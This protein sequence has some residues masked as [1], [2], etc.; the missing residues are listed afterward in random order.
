M[1]YLLDE[2][3]PPFFA[4]LLNQTFYPEHENPVVLSARYLDFLGI[5][6]GDWIPVLE[7]Q[8][9]D[10]NEGWTVVTRDRMD[11]HRTEMFASTLKFAILADANWSSARRHQLWENL[12]RH[13]PTLE[14]HSV[15]PLSKV[16]RMSYRGHISE[17]K[18]SP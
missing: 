14:R 6:D 13:W 7:Q 9:R 5:G 16:F 17:H 4:R 10:D 2:G 12:S 18:Q 11:E 15:S 8:D 1:R 3:W